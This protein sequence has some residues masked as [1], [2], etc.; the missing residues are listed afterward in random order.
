MGTMNRPGR[1][2]FTLVE[3]LVVMAIIGV[4]VG[5][6]LPAV[7]YVRNAA[8]RTQCLSQMHQIAVAMDNY[9]DTKGSRGTFPYAAQLPTVT[10]QYPSLAKVLGPFME[11]NDLVYNCPGDIYYALTDASG[12]IIYDANGNVTPDYSTSFWQKQGL[13]YEY[14]GWGPRSNPPLAG[15]TRPQAYGSKDNM[16]KIKNAETIVLANDFDPF[17]GPTRDAGSRNFVFLDGHADSP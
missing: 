9:M 14:N 11:T 6:L 15:K 2:G 1:R 7:Q 4:L 17:H 12:N 13:S 16:N 3:L 5:L 10:P 8:R